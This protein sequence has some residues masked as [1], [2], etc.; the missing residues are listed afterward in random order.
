MRVRLILAAVLLSAAVYAAPDER[1]EIYRQAVNLYEHG[2]YER[3][4]NLLDKIQGDP[5]SDGYAVLCA[6]KM[7]S[8]GFEDRLHEYERT[9]RRSS[10]S[11]Q[12]DYEYA[13]V[14]FDRG[15]YDEA[16]KRFAEVERRYLN[17]KYYPE[18]A[19]KT[20]YA[21]FIRGNYAK[22]RPQFM[23]VEALPM[24]D[25]KAPAR[26]ALG[27]MAYCE[28][29]FPEAQKWLELSVTDPRFEALSS[30]Y[31]VDCRF[32]QKDYDYVITKGVPLYKEEPGVRKAH[33]ARI[34]SE[35]YLVKGDKAKAKEYYAATSKDNMSRSD[36]FYAGSVLY[37]V[38][39]FKGAIANYEKMSDRA[40]S[41]GQIANYQLANAYMKTGN[42]VAAMNAFKA[43]SE[44]KWNQAMQEDAMFNYAKLSFDLNKDTAPFSVY[45]DRYNTSKRGDEI[46]GYMALVS[47]YNRDYAAAVEAYDKI[48]ELD[49]AQQS[50]Y[51]K[52]YYLRG[53]QLMSSGAYTDAAACMRAAA[54]YL[55]KQDPL[56]QLARYW[57]AEANYRSENYDEAARL[58]ADLYNISALDGMEEGEILPYN[59]AF[60]H[61]K[62]GDYASASR[63]FDIYLS[64]GGKTCRKDALVR[65]GD[66]DFAVRNYQGAIESYRTAT[67][68]IGVKDD[69]YPYCQL[70]MAYGLSGDKNAKAD[71]LGAVLK[72]APGTPMYEEGLYEL[73]RANMD[74]S[75]NRKALEAFTILK[76]STNDRETQAKALIGMGMVYRNITDYDRAL[77]SYK[78]VV[79]LLPGS[80]Y[81]DDAL[82]AIES[83]YQARQQPEKYLEYIEQNG[84][85]AGK[86]D[87]DKEELYFNTAEQVFLSGNYVQAASSLQ[88]YIDTYPNGVHLTN[89]LFYLAESYSALGNK[90][91]ACEYYSRVADSG[92]GSSFVEASLLHLAELSYSLE[93]YSQA[94]VAYSKLR[95]EGKMEENRKEALYGMMR[96]AYKAHDYDAAASAASEVSASSGTSAALKREADYIKA[97]SYMATSRRDEALALFRSLSSQPATAEGAEARY[98]IIQDAFDRADYDAV[99]KAVFDFS[100]KSG[101]QNYWLARAYLT[102]ADTFVQ[103]GKT[104]QAKATLESIRDGYT[105]ERPDEEIQDLV[106]SRLYKLNN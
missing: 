43:A 13:L 37:A 3:A 52:A 56:G 17:E 97:K 53:E 61:F 36:Y 65:R 78:E 39:D 30:F 54:Y 7:Q 24:S 20:G 106:Q 94:Y 21:D 73:G 84:L 101:G 9:W 8:E 50:N 67:K 103:I 16:S 89:A 5:M 82:F 47:L 104:E 99:Q 88:K 45:I 42:N 46:Y 79:K 15:R 41:L 85:A 86:S 64:E 75:D 27:Y 2:M 40:D 38:D 77:A 68:E 57:Q 32:M 23:E 60:S 44:Q 83:I 22:A 92:S 33:L 66:C 59:V 58:F 102:L 1:T 71:V 91:K 87:S 10:I 93:R 74:I 98:I 48:D 55:P 14:L 25:F 18:L 29:D 80:Q 70:A 6:I 72:S 31:L 105:P 90:E 51:V 26:Y 81:S 4:A 76:D 34:I 96:S 28:K 69:L 11:N 95:R 62:A 63:W 35:S 49:A 12:I 19:F 100:D